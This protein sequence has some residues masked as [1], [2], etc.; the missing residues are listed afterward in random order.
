[1]SKSTSF[2]QALELTPIDGDLST[3]AWDVPDLWKQGRGAWGGLVVGAL[4]KSVEMQEELDISRRVRTISSQIFAPIPVGPNEI[5][6]TCLRRGSGMSTWQSFVRDENGVP[7][8]QG[9]V[10]TGKPRATDLAGVES[11][12][13]MASVPA[14]GDWREVPTAL[15]VPPLGPEFCAQLE[16]RPRR[17]MPMSGEAPWTEGWI[18]I[19]GLTAWTAHLLMGI[20]D[21]W[22]PAA[23]VA[24]PGPRPMATVSFGA[25]LLMDPSEVD[26]GE[27]LLHEATVTAA[28]DGFTSELR[29]LWT[30]DGR[31]VLENH[32]SIVIVA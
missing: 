12:W 20:V 14:M 28:Q 29:R 13:G 6:V 32:Q 30:P 19:P 8:A 25:H 22:L 9:V 31:L 16:Y 26:P 2:E 3:L 24:L 27:P 21:A 17:G 4:V 7:L 1:M 15:I 5:S 10:I 23:Y 11:S 18:S